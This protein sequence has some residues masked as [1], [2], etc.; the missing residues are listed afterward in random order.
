MH[1][2]FVLHHYGHE[3]PNL[4]FLFH[5]VIDLRQLFSPSANTKTTIVTIQTLLKFDGTATCLDS[6]GAAPWAFAPSLE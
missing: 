3:A 1:V 4:N 6:L 5:L 2:I